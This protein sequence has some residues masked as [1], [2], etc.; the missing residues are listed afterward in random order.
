MPLI[1]GEKSAGETEPQRERALRCFRAAQVAHDP[2]GSPGFA[3][4]EPPVGPP[5]Q[6]PLICYN[7]G[8]SGPAFPDWVEKDCA[9]MVSM[10]SQ[11]QPH[12]HEPRWD[13][14]AILGVGLIGGSIGIDLLRLRLARHVVG[15]GR[16]EEACAFARH[17]GAC[18]S[19]TIDLPRGLADAQLIVVC[20]PLGRI[21]EDVRE[22]ASFAKI[23]A[24]VTDVGSTK[25]TIVSELD[26]ELPHEMHYV[27]SHPLAGGEK[28]GPGAAV[29]GL[30]KGRTVVVTPGEMTRDE[31]V[32]SITAF[33]ESLGAK[34][35]KMTPGE[36]DQLVA[37][38]SHLPHLIAAAFVAATPPESLK[39][40]AGGWIDSTRIAAGDPELWRDILLSNR[41][42]VLAAL[43]R[44][45]ESLARF[46][47]A[48]EH[49]DAAG[50]VE[51]LR[52]AKQTRDAVGS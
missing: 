25:A 23:G 11:P 16:R 21:S 24:T 10:P 39:L 34:V 22:A 18:T 4:N 40:V 31:D 15:I 49:D 19:T 35:V 43:A 13:T 3:S 27:G 42:N 7:A 47:Q 12:T 2:V 9:R 51:A 41:A 20:T 50:L 17:M 45:E 30:F 8:D 44:Y 52:E 26:R 28:A 48:L 5:P 29:A 38:A 6:T 36:H 32:L 37:G 33:W 1:I 46:R 14:V